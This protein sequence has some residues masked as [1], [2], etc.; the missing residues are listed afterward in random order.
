MS[1]REKILGWVERRDFK[2]V[3]ESFLAE[4]L[5]VPGTFYSEGEKQTAAQ[6]ST[7]PNPEL[8]LKT[9]HLLV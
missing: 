4:G 9:D 8:E 6:F 5:V 1:L 7:F 2:H 3:T